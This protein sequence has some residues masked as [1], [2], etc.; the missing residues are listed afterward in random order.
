MDKLTDS[1]QRDLSRLQTDYQKAVEKALGNLDATYLRKIQANFFRCGLKCCEDLD[2]SIAEVQ[3]C[4]ER[5]ETPLSQAHELMQSEVSTF[6]TRLQVCAS[7]C[8][9]Q[10]R[11]KLSSDTTES[12]L[13]NAQRE[14][15]ACSQ[16]CVDNQLSTGLPA[17]ITRLKDQLQKLNQN[18]IMN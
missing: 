9:N 12:Q 3:R 10:A 2:A 1:L 14:V 17:L 18:Q 8:A 6:Q 4:V 13:K 11:D 15:L 5:C 16:K 7:E